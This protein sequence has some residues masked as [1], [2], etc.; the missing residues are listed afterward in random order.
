MVFNT[1][2]LLNFWCQFGK[3]ERERKCPDAWM[4]KLA[5]NQGAADSSKTKEEEI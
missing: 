5:M 3:E 2:P 1:K 4:K